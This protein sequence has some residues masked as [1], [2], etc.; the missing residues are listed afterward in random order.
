MSQEQQ[1]PLTEG[2]LSSLAQ[3]LK[4]LGKDLSPKEKWFLN[5]TLQSGIAFNQAGE[6][7][8]Y[9]MQSAVEGGTLYYPQSYQQQWGGKPIASATSTEVRIV[10]RVTF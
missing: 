4:E 9:T 8:G 10:V 7:Q 2:E 6:M 3:K 1:G 5:E